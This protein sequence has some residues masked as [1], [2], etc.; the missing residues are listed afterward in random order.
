MCPPTMN[1]IFI[2]W[3]REFNYYKEQ[4]LDSTMVKH[5][6]KGGMS[7]G[8]KCMKS[9]TKYTIVEIQPTLL[10]QIHFPT[11]MYITMWVAIN[12]EHSWMIGVK[13]DEFCR[14][15][16]NTIDLPTIKEIIC[17]FRLSNERKSLHDK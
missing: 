9:K 1:V 15:N 4:P 2:S 8:T 5:K 3:N 17:N 6:L 12:K 16:W 10:N 14:L 11:C 7:F 13:L